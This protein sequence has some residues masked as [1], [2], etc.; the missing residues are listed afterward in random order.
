MKCCRPCAVPHPSTQHTSQRM[1]GNNMRTLS[2]A[3]SVVECLRHLPSTDPIPQGCLWPPPPA[4]Q[5]PTWHRHISLVQLVYT[6]DERSQCSDV[7]EWLVVALVLLTACNVEVAGCSCYGAWL[8]PTGPQMQL[9]GRLAALLWQVENSMGTLLVKNVVEHT[10]KLLLEMQQMPFKKCVEVP[11]IIVGLDAKKEHLVQLLADGSSCKVVLLHGMGGIG[12]TTLAKAVFNHLHQHHPTLPCCFLPLDGS[13]DDGGVVDKQR[14]LLQELAGGQQFTAHSA[15]QG[16]QLLVQKLQGRKVLVVVD[17]VWGSQLNMLLPQSLVEELGEGSMVLVTSR[18]STAADVY[19]GQVDVEE[20]ELT[21]LSDQ[22]ALELFCKYAYGSS[23]PPAGDDK[24]VKGVVARC[25]GLPMAVE[26]VGRHLGARRTNKQEALNRVDEALQY[27]FGEEVAG[28]HKT[29]FAALR[30]SWDALGFKEKGALLD[31]VW[32]LKGR[33]WELV[34]AYCAGDYGALARLCQ[35]GLVKRHRQ[36]ATLRS[37]EVEVVTVHDTIVELC[38][39]CVQFQH[40]QRLEVAL[41]AVGGAALAERIA[42]VRRPPRWL[43]KSSPVAACIAPAHIGPEGSSC[44]VHQF[45][46]M[47]QSTDFWMRQCACF[48]QDPRWVLHCTK[49]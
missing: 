26:V 35:L 20:V 40:G 32:F 45:S 24:R 46:T 49:Q 39:A 18:E 33:E 41:S 25:G 7:I 30:L 2:R 11:D 3:T 17:N 9:V 28:T 12:K 43:L 22:E 23:S 48:V 38:K 6:E 16:R 37:D 8:R 29:L 19:Q 47:H 1:P 5:H 15:E 34:E 31:I 42:E 13:L 4:E 14:Q 36:A 44:V 27:A 10:V 21:C